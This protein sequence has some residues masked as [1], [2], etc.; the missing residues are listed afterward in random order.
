MGKMC[1][2]VRREYWCQGQLREMEIPQQRGVFFSQGS[3]CDI[4]YVEVV[5]REAKLK[6]LESFPY[7]VTISDELRFDFGEQGQ[8]W[9]KWLTNNLK[10]H[11]TVVWDTYN[12]IHFKHEKDAT[13]F[14]LRWA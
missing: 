13:F 6:T 11:E 7:A 1:T 3:R 4:F 12:T 14:A 2:L 8:L 5:M 9:F 10:W